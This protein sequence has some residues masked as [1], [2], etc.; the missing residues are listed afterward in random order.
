[1]RGVLYSDG[2][3]G[4]TCNSIIQT[5][6]NSFSICLQPGSLE[7][8]CTFTCLHERGKFR[9]QSTP[10]QY[11][12]PLTTLTVSWVADFTIMHASRNSL[13]NDSRSRR[14][15]GRAGSRRMATLPPR[16][17]CGCRISYLLQRL[18][19]LLGCL[20][21]KGVALFP[22]PAPKLRAPAWL[23]HSKWRAPTWH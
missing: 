1:M 8:M 12:L 17:K 23:S 2:V 10:Q 15:C 3:R 11:P 16:E 19:C 20:D 21:S 7:R 22:P 18:A 9:V 6:I 13:S 14:P 4:Q 5:L